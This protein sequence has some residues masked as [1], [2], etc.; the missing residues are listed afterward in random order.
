MISQQ[1]TEELQEILQEEYSTSLS[2]E[3]ASALGSSLV[4]LF[5]K[6]GQVADK[7]PELFKNKYENHE[8]K[9]AVN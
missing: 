8:A 4:R 3:Q 6:L 5:S 1:L 9:P 7:H 2:T